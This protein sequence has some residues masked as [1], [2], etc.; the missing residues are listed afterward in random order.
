MDLQVGA[1]SGTDS[2]TAIR[3]EFL[4]ARIS[5]LTAYKRDV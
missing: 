1:M 2:I 4:E 3:T 5:A